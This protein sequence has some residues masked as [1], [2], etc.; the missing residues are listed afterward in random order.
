MAEAKTKPTMT[1][2]AAFLKGV[3][4]DARREECETLVGLMKKIT[5]AE[6]R[7]WG[8]GLVGFGTYHYKYAS[9][10]EGDWPLAGFAARKTNL[11]VYVMDGVEPHAELMAKLGTFTTGKACLYMKKLSDVNLGV[12]EKIVARSVKA[13]KARDKA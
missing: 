12:L 5:K 10:R 6:P 13:V 9:G 2:V 7:I 1:S 3:Q 11:T 4:P 8:T